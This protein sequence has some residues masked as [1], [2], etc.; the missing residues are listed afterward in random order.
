LYFFTKVKKG[1]AFAQPSTKYNFKLDYSTIS[2]F[3]ADL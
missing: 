2:R 3:A 1:F